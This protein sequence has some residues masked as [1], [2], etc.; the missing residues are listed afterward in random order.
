MMLFHGRL[1]TETQDVR[2]RR[3]RRCGQLWQTIHLF[4]R[5]MFQD[6]PFNHRLAGGFSNAESDSDEILSAQVIDQ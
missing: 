4:F 5:K 6:V 2:Y 1:N 3:R